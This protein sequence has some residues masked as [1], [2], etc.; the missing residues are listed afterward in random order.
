M[1]LILVLLSRKTEVEITQH[2]RTFASNHSF[3]LQSLGPDD[4]SM[5]KPYTRSACKINLFC[6]L[7]SR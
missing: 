5:I 1:K 2:L 4:L 3:V 6:I 7:N